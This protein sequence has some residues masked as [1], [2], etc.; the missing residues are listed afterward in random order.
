MKPLYSISSTSPSLPEIVNPD[1]V[2]IQEALS[3][4]TRWT[5]QRY[6]RIKP[7]FKLNLKV[8]ES[9]FNISSVIKRNVFPTTSFKSDQQIDFASIELRLFTEQLRSL[10]SDMKS[11][12]LW[13]S[14][15]VNYRFKEN[16]VGFPLYPIIYHNAVL[17]YDLG[18][19]RERNCICWSTTNSQVTR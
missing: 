19:G 16:L 1:N 17:S 18:V 9:L 11:D 12:S 5:S 10:A 2:T 6:V 13:F 7:I 3:L 14:L 15:T 8:G 4:T